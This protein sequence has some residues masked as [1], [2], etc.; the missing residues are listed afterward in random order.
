MS[1]FKCTIMIGRKIVFQVI[2]TF[3]E[4]QEQEYL[5]KI[6]S[7]NN[8]DIRSELQNVVNRTIGSKKYEKEFDFW[9]DMSIEEYAIKYP[10][11]LIC[12]SIQASIY[13]TGLFSGFDWNIPVINGTTQ[14][15]VMSELENY[16]WKCVHLNN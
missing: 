10:K 6:Q 8:S 11:I 15:V 1:K 3:T 13:G 2:T 9:E 16:H 12:A 7:E 14:E 4:A 5:C